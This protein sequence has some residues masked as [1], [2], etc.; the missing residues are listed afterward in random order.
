M[1]ATHT[2]VVAHALASERG[3]IEALRALL[4]KVSGSVSLWAALSFV[5]G[6]RGTI[7]TRWTDEERALLRRA[8]L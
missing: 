8:G 3:E 4:R 6:V 1:S 7:P 2:D 5:D